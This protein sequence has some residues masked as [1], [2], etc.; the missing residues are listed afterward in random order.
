M[1][2]FDCLASSA[3]SLTLLALPWLLPSLAPYRA[4]AAATWA[5]LTLFAAAS[6]Y[7]SPTAALL[8]VH[9]TE[10]PYNMLPPLQRLLLASIAEAA[11]VVLT[12]G[13]G[14]LVSLGFRMLSQ[15]R[16]GFGDRLCRFVPLREVVRPMHFTAL[17]PVTAAAL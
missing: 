11:L 15:Q 5:C 9:A 10:G 4:A 3:I 1:S 17:A 8:R 6:G 12:C 16:Q 13:L 14:V 7:T 2:A